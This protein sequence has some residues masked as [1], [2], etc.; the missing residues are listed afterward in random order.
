MRTVAL[1]GLL[2]R[3]LRLA[4]TATAVALGVM[5]VAGTYVFTDTINASFDKIF[6]SS[7]ASSDLVVTPAVEASDSASGE[8]PPLPAGLVARVAAV[9]GVARAEGAISDQG[10]T[11]LS[12]GNE[13]LSGQ[14]PS[15]LGSTST[16]GFGGTTYD[17]GRAPRTPGEV[18]IDPGSAK[19]AG[20]GVGGRVAIAGDEG[21][22][23]YL[24]SGLV[25]LG[26]TSIGGASVAEVTLPEAQRIAGKDGVDRIDVALGPG[27]SQAAVVADV[28]RAVGGAAQVRTG[29]QQAEAQSSDIEDQLSF[30]PTTLLAF[31]GI[32]VFVGAFLIFNTFSIT[33]AQRAREFAL[34]RTLGAS[35]AQVLRSVLL[36]GLAIGVVG[37]LIG[38]ALGLLVA[39]GLKA[40]FSLVGVDLPSQGT[41]VALRTVLVALGV[42]VVVTV[43]SSIVP[44]RRATQ[45]PPVAA[46]REGVALPVTRGSRWVLPAA[47]GIT[48]IGVALLAGGLLVGDGS[49]AVVGAGAAVTFLGIALLSPVLVGPLASVVGRPL[50]RVAGVTGRLARENAVRQ[51]G[52][53]AVTAAA[54]MVGVALVA[55]ATIFTAGVRSTIDDAIDGGIRGQVIVQNADGFTPFSAA[56][57]QAIGRVDGVGEISP[58]LSARNLRVDGERETLTAID[59]ATF[60]DV[61]DLDVSGLGATDAIVSE[62]YASDHDLRVGSALRV[63]APTGGGPSLDLRVAR[64]AD[65]SALILGDVLV[66]NRVAERFGVRDATFAL[67]GY[68]PGADPTRT[69]AAI[70]RVVDR[71]FPQVEALT[72]AEFKDEQ[73]GQVTQLLGLIYALLALSIL[74]SLF[75]IVNTLVLSVTERIRE[76]G[77]LRAIGTSRRQVR[78][79]IR[80]E[81]V[82]TALIGGILGLGVGILM[83]A[84]VGSSLDGFAFTLPVASL[85]IVLVLAGLAGV[86]AAVLP[87]RRASRLDV[88]E[89]LAHE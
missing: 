73:G 74:V 59:P 80:Y 21:R 71:R 44:A 62:S 35:R 68:A 16:Q 76:L 39:A 37:S 11:L 87:A 15:I 9:D 53:T 45:V 84:L 75:G 8:V 55:F 57:L 89:A 51:P 4:L 58:A 83:A 40:L 18:A 67:V 69:K 1:R 66:T 52:R 88:L 30:L 47:V 22:R 86:A 50:E 70:D 31:A 42:G 25:S 3:R 56:A 72:L 54:L 13:R 63:Q 12:L 7:N 20:V 79:M 6:A 27:R 82:I 32:A 85:V 49:L 5:L 46:L 38:L 28:R 33:V 78:R 14:G 65:I 23:T 60:G 48:L 81:S 26:G 10:A 24:V 43:I 17:E 29:A 61:Y 2:A 77:M 64:V 36:E 19:R 34:L 41:V